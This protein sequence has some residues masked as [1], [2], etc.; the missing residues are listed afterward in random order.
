MSVAVSL[1]VLRRFGSFCVGS[2]SFICS[3]GLLLSVVNWCYCCG[4]VVSVVVWWYLWYLWWVGG[5]WSVW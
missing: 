1:V 4:L 2:G 5:I 3:I